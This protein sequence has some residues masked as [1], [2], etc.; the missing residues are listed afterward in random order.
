MC[1]GWISNCRTTDDMASA[2]FMHTFRYT[3]ILMNFSSSMTRK[4]NTP[5]TPLIWRLT[6]RVARNDRLGYTELKTT[7]TNEKTLKK[8]KCNI[9]TRIELRTFAA[10]NLQKIR[11]LFASHLILA[12]KIWSPKLNSYF[13]QMNLF[14]LK[15]LRTLIVMF[16]C[17]RLRYELP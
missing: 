15:F 13:R 1:I 16:K 4:K 6:N 7:F 2:F 17:H 8:M 11:F 3:R 14:K 5:R 12:E 10:L 9:Q